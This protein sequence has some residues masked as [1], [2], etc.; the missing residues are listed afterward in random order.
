MHDAIVIGGGPAGLQAAL[1]LG[2][3]HRDVLLLDAGRYRN[4][5]ADAMHNVI[6]H[7]GDTPAAF[8]AAARRD[9]ARY[10]TVTVRDVEVQ[11]VRVVDADARDHQGFEVSTADGTESAR[12]LLLATGVVDELPPTPGVAELF[13]T[14]AAHCPY[15][16]G[17]EYAGTRVGILGAGPHVGH[18][19][20]LMARVA[21]SLTVFTDGAEP[22]EELRA[23]LD[24]R[25]ADVVTEP[26]ARVEPRTLDGGHPGARVVLDDGS[27]VEVGGLM[28]APK[29]RQAAPFAEQLGL[30][31]RD[32]GAVAI[33]AFG[34]TSLPGVFAAG[35]LA[36][37]AD[38]PMAVSS[39]LAAAAAGQIAAASLGADLLAAGL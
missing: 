34:R 9:V 21:S 11:K 37:S 33:D 17:H 7:D 29:Q 10:A 8:R 16:H 1:T 30:D 31:L 12:R 15:C 36:H 27:A 13:G 38:F 35:D 24:V 26:V 25:R 5:P 23:T 2:R 14:V 20:G 19:S 39:V 3:T 32:S 6:G 28:V 4:D 18:T 22:T